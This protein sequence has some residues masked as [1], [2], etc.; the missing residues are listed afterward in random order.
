MIDLPFYWHIDQNRVLLDRG[1]V[2]PHRVMDVRGHING[3]LTHNRVVPDH[4]RCVPDNSQIHG[5]SGR[6]PAISAPDEEGHR[7]DEQD[8][9]KRL[10]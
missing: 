4:F 5:L 2:C 7:H 9:E 6:F 10:D 8:A 3:L 1:E